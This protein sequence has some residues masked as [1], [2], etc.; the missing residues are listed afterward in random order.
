MAARTDTDPT[1]WDVA[2]DDLNPHTAPA[3]AYRRGELRMRH[4]N[5][6][7]YIVVAATEDEAITKAR[8]AD[9][10]R[11]MRDAYGRSR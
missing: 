11:R 10:D 7:R 3:Y 4:R 6:R 5:T 2:V 1:E 8:Q 9:H